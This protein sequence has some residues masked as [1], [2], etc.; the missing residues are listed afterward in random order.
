[1]RGSHSRK[2]THINPNSVQMEFS[3][4]V[5]K[6]FARLE[7]LMDGSK[8]CSPE[9]LETLRHVS[10]GATFNATQTLTSIMLI[11]QDAVTHLH[12]TGDQR[13]KG[14]LL[15]LMDELDGSERGPGHTPFTFAKNPSKDLLR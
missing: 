13:V 15:A 8:H 9:T 1:M 6:Q 2:A 4:E 12:S 14:A 3:P 7:A 10:E 11:V 5:R